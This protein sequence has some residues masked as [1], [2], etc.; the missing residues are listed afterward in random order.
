[1]PAE[2]P[3]ALIT[4]TRKGIGRHLAEH[5]IGRGYAVEG[6]SREAADWTCAGYTHHR[7]DVSDEGQVKS[8]LADIRKRH[9]RLDVLIN[10]AGIASM[11]HTLLTPTST[12]QRIWNTNY[13][14]SFVVIRESVKLMQKRRYGRIVNLGSVAA[15]LK[16]EGEAMYASSKAA[17]VNLTQILAYELAEFGITVNLVGPT[18]IDT[19]LIRGVPDAKMKALVSRLAIKRLGRMDDVSNVI[20]FFIRPESEFVTGQV[21]YLGGV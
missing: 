4:G 16:L 14:G 12:V 19:D 5:L 18:P 8:M 21:I 6:C 11:N 17:L 9:G 10:N 15:P 13:L 3:V 2:Q 1:M 7:A 20:D